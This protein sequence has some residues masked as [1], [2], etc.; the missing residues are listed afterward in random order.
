MLQTQRGGLNFDQKK[1]GLSVSWV[2]TVEDPACPGLPWSGPWAFLGLWSTLLPLLCSCQLLRANCQVLFFCLLYRNFAPNRGRVSGQSFSTRRTTLARRVLA[3]SKGGPEAWKMT[4][5]TVPT[6]SN[7][8]QWKRTPDLLRL[9]VSPAA[10]SLW[11]SPV[12]R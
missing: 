12:K 1:E 10:H 2:L 3:S 9:T 6:S 4:S 8:S 5:N 11:P 7:F